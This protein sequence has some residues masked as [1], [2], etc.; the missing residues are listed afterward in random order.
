MLGW[1]DAW[2][3]LGYLLIPM[4]VLATGAL[5]I[6]APLTTFLPIFLM[7][8]AVQRYALRRLTRGLAPQTQALVFDLIRMPANLQATLRLF[9]PGERAF[10]VT[11][12]GKMGDRRTRMPVP[13]LLAALLAASLLA[14]AWAG[15]TLAGLTSLH[16]A[17]PWAVYATLGWLTVNAVLLVA[18]AHRIRCERF[19]SERRAVVRFDTDA[20]GWIAG[21]HVRL[22]DMSLTGARYV[23][24]RD[25]PQR[26]EHVR[27]GIE[28][29]RGEAPHDLRGV[30]RDVTAAGDTASRIVSIEFDPGQ[31]R[32]RAAIAIALFANGSHYDL[33]D[34]GSVQPV[35]A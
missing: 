33:E 4:V 7:A 23:S 32:E 12:K 29:H 6:T 15:C 8:F 35:A 5:P 2:R 11:A 3:L 30:A 21:S 14:A 9:A 28:L 26:G 22:V 10:S 31:E 34:D 20:E 18:A 1:F 17:T 24:E 19:G 25:L 13:R 16:Y 27:V